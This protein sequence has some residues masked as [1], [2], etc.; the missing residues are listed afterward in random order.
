M[1]IN[2]RIIK[3][4]EDFAIA[5]YLFFTQVNKKIS[6]DAVTKWP[7]RMAIGFFT[8]NKQNNECKL[9]KV[10][11]DTFFF[12]NLHFFDMVCVQLYNDF[13]KTKKLPIETSYSA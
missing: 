8:F 2:V 3:I 9:D 6:E 4:N 10:K 13:Q 11:S 12:A 7:V 1:G 5:E